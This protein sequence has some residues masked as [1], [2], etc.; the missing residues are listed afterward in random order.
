MYTRELHLSIKN[1]WFR[2][3]CFNTSY[4]YFPKKKI[5]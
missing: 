3:R 4:T 5:F 2:W 1:V